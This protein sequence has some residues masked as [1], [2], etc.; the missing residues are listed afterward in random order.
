MENIKEIFN[1]NKLKHTKSRE[2]ILSVFYETSRP[3]DA[4]FLIKKIKDKK[5]DR[6]T[7]YRTLNTFEVKKI[8]HRVDLRKDSVF[9][10]LSLNQHHHHIVCIKCG[11]IEK[12]DYCFENKLPSKILSGSKKFKSIE[13][14]SFEFF[15]KCNKCNTKI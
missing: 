4:D 6:V 8:I 14:H 15:G 3:I 11:D 1:K 7:V 10:E 9:Y 5:I 13:D 2:K 12:I